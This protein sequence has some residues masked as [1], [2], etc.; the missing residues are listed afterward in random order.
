MP[1]G[2]YVFRATLTDKAGR[3]FDRSGTVVLL[4]KD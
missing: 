4:K 3:T 2:T 1:E